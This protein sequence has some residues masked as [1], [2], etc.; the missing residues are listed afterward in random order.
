MSARGTQAEAMIRAL[1]ALAKLDGELRERLSS[2]AALAARVD[3]L[4]SSTA[5]LEKFVEGER[6][7][8]PFDPD[9]L[10]GRRRASLI[11]EVQLQLTE[12]ARELALHQEQLQMSAGHPDD[13]GLLERW[14]G[15]ARSLLP[16]DVIAAYDALV[17]AGRYPAIVPL[18]R[19][20]CSGCH[21]R[22]P[23][24]LLNRVALGHVLERC[25]HCQRFLHLP[26]TAPSA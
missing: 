2:G 11:A 3:R 23:P 19:G 12:A 5:I 9:S 22:V 8:A 20:F 15:T 1:V 17:R 14:R 16:P 25:P 21:L 24:Q 18:A 7:T 13:G 26:H 4:Q 10:E 6:L